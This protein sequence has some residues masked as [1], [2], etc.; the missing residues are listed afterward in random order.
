MDT[1]SYAKVHE[2]QQNHC[3]SVMAYCVHGNI[4]ANMYIYIY[5]TIYIIYKYNIYMY[6]CIYIYLFLYTFYI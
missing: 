1:S 4:Y 6:I 2:L 3:G 5:I